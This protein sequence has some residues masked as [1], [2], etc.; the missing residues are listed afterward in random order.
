MPSMAS[1]PFSSSTFFQNIFRYYETI[2]RAQGSSRRMAEIIV[3][4]SEDMGGGRTVPSQPGD[5]KFENVTF[6]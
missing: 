1:L 4:K 5:L 3:E 2:K 6:R